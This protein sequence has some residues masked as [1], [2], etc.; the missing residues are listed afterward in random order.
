M[1]WITRKWVIFRNYM[2]SPFINLTSKLRMSTLFSWRS[3]WRKST[4]STRRCSVMNSVGELYDEYK[5]QLS[6]HTQLKLLSSYCS[7]RIQSRSVRLMGRCIVSQAQYT[8]CSVLTKRGGVSESSFVLRIPSP[9]YFQHTLHG[10]STYHRISGT[11][12]MQ[13][14]WFYWNIERGQWAQR[15]VTWL[16]EAVRA[17]CTL[18]NNKIYF[19]VLP[20]F[21]QIFFIWDFSLSRLWKLYRDLIRYITV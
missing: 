8:A 3:S 14:P 9:S 4:W 11:G 5:I 18:R 2:V 12:D 7:R 17:V 19:L 10:S 13:D 16:V 21:F 15:M 6:E 20:T 1:E